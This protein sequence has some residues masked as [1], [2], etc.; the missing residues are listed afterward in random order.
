MGVLTARAVV[1][2]EDTPP[3]SW[4]TPSWSSTKFPR[5]WVSGRLEATR[6]AFAATDFFVPPATRRALSATFFP[7]SPQ[8][9]ILTVFIAMQNLF[10]TYLCFPA[11]GAPNG[12]QDLQF[13]ALQGSGLLTERDF[14]F[15]HY[16]C[17]QGWF[18]TSRI[19]SYFVVLIFILVVL[20]SVV[21]L[22]SVQIV[23]LAQY[24]SLL[25]AHS[26]MGVVRSGAAQHNL[27]F[28][29]GTIE[30]FSANFLLQNVFR[31]K[32]F[33]RYICCNKVKRLSW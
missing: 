13:D 8:K 12:E 28:A 4:R 11:F 21:M 2:L 10:V 3:W 33:G 15:E 24:L 1:E 17:Q 29:A 26:G 23:R 19:D 25:R 5:T 9:V 22:A 32:W 6:R 30:L 20:I 18:R 7:T 14:S 27:G 16:L 31:P